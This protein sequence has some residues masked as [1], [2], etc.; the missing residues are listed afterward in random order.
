M[1]DI[2]ERSLF[3]ISPVTGKL[4]TELFRETHF[5]FVVLDNNKTSHQQRG[6]LKINKFVLAS[7]LTEFPRGLF[8]T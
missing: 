5:P 3:E 7:S 8:G 2:K 4:F 1:P 6:G